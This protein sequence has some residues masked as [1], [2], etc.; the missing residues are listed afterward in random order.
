MGGGA[1]IQKDYKLP[2][3]ILV[4]TGFF[5]KTI[6]SDLLWPIFGLLIV[7]FFT[8]IAINKTIKK[9]KRQKRWVRPDPEK[10]SID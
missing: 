9:P 7:G 1:Y 8:N 2:S 3:A 10:K 5:T 6:M 4:C